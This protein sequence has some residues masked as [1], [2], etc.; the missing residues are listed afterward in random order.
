MEAAAP[1]MEGTNINPKELSTVVCQEDNTLTITVKGLQTMQLNDR[2]KEPN[3]QT[4]EEEQ[5]RKLFPKKT[6]MKLSISLLVV[7]ILSMMIQVCT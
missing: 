2:S 5:Y 4:K 7:G 1:L 3:D 6:I